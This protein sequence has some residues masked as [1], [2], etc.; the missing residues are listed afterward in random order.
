LTKS[1]LNSWNAF[2]E[3]VGTA[4]P[5]ESFNTWI[6]PMR[7]LKIDGAEILVQVPSQFYYDWIA[8]HYS[9]QI[10]DAIKQ[11]FGD[12]FK[13]AYSILENDNRSLLKDALTRTN[14]I[15]SPKNNTDS[16][17]NPRYSFSNFIE[18]ECN[19]FARAAALA[20]SEAPG[21]TKFNP[22]VI[23]GGTGLGKTH[24]IQAIGNFALKHKNSHKVIY[25]TSEEFTSDFINSVKENKSTDF[26]KNYRSADLLIVDDVQFFEGKERTQMEF[27]HTFN[28]LY[29][30]GKQIVLSLD[31]PPMELNDMQARLI[32]R[33]QSGLVADIQPPD[34]ETRVAILRKRI[35]NDGI[36]F[37][38]EIIE[39]LAHNIDNN[40]REMEG[41][42]IR[43]MAHASITGHEIDLALAKRLLKDMIKVKSGTIS[44]ESIQN[45]VA[46]WADIPSDLIRGNS[47]KKQIARARQVAMYLCSQLTRH[48]LKSTGSHFGN[49]DHSTVIHSIDVIKNMI[50]E[51]NNFKE[52]ISNLKRKLESHI[53]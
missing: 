5:R 24:L 1:Q 32:S 29:Q 46:E 38:E 30:S 51:D 50:K 16:K 3:I 37:S 52:E 8:E 31:R 20:I 34:Y 11:T 33:F 6:K 22:L 48:T 19:S 47:R 12:N 53:S 43:L 13:I 23:Y 45:V 2:I 49:R 4:I 21:T 28:N 27:F 26:S 25:V 36:Y 41:S 14:G 44:V 17:L 9:T 10:N 7:P 15:I 35:E 40:I 18:G 42:L 39:F